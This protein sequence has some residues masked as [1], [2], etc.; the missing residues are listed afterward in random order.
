M[1]SG[2][3][4][5][6]LELLM[7][8][9]GV[10]TA[11]AYAREL[12]VSKR[13]IYTYLD[14]LTPYLKERGFDVVKTPSKGI[15][16][17]STEKGEV[18]FAFIED[19]YSIASRRYELL[20][21]VIL[22]EENVSLIDYCE[23]FYVS[24]SSIRNDVSFF[25]KLLEPFPNISLVI[26][27]GFIQISVGDETDLI[28]AVVYINEILCKEYNLN[29]KLEYFNYIYDSRVVNSVIKVIQD[30]IHSL[31]LKIAEHYVTHIYF[32]M[33]TLIT[34]VKQGKHIQYVDNM[35][36]YDRLKRIPDI[37]LAKQFLEIIGMELKIDFFED[38]IAFLS[39]YLRADR[40][41]ISNFEKIDKEDLMIYRDVFRK[42][43]KTLNIEINESDDLVQNLLLHFNA[44]VFR[45]R[46]GIVVNNNLTESIKK[47]FGAL[48]NLILIILESVNDQLKIKVTE[49]E[50]GFLLIH[51]QN[52]IERQK[53]TKNILL[54]CPHGTVVSNLILS[55]VRELLP[56]YNFLETISVE[57]IKDVNVN[58]ID[59]IIS[60]VD[61]PD[62]KKPVVKI[63]PILSKED[64]ANIMNFYQNLVLNQLNDYH[65]CKSLIKF[66]NRDLIFEMD[67]VSK[68]D[69]IHIICNKLVNLGI[70]TKEYESSLLRRETLGATD[71][72]YSFAIPHGDM[73][74]V[75][76]SQIAVVL[77][78][79]P[80]KW[81][82]HL[83]NIVIFFTISSQDLLESKDI[84]DD[85]YYLMHSQEFALELNDG[86][87]MERFLNFLKKEPYD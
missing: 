34:R 54:V 26:S 66:I 62:I 35:L 78:K 69:I 57:R 56:S 31:N 43:E 28:N 72:I 38:D 67:S 70:V 79:K 53:K 61:I 5:Q 1:L 87:S 6:L 11:A 24:E 20:N 37:L 8:Q 73:K 14:E 27:K 86:L 80:I 33:I 21:R 55:Q 64:L 2:K 19:E 52:I 23:E 84:L 16:V 68:K 32:V 25:Q 74:F 10:S 49:D 39:G 82:K 15:E 36:Y 13:S 9:Q 59:F 17:N 7:K 77:L 30:Y 50:V 60:T 51:I 85:I 45:L 40:I 47:E 48:F 44:M 42:L 4:K 29:N 22:N 83:I 46:N 18:Q 81:N 71:N 3:Q 58:S 41:Q 65:D 75:L 76:K 63:S 12:G